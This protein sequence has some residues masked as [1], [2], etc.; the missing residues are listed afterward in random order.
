MVNLAA[1]IPESISP[2]IKGE[3]FRYFV[4]RSN[5]DTTKNFLRALDLVISEEFTNKDT[6]F[7]LKP[8]K[9]Q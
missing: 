8:P 7:L 9:S 5:I 2:S 4:N 3:L 6:L 1:V